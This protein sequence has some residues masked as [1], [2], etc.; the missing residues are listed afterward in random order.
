MSRDPFQ[1]V[2][3]WVLGVCRCSSCQLEVTWDQNV[4]LFSV[5]CRHWQGD[6][7]VSGLA[8]GDQLDLIRKPV[9]LIRQ[10]LRRTLLPQEIFSATLEAGLERKMFCL[11]RSFCTWTSWLHFRCSCWHF[12]WRFEHVA[13]QSWGRWGSEETGHSNEHCPCSLLSGSENEKMLF[14]LFVKK[15]LEKP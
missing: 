11:N 6:A 12:R 15:L 10:V 7:C 8:G 9:D 5:A 14:L 4:R 13:S 3:R 1:Q 2:W